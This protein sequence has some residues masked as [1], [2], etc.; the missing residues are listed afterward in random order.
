MQVTPADPNGKPRA[1][2]YLLAAAVV[3]L[4][5]FAA[6]TFGS[7]GREAP[8]LLFLPAV[9]FALAVGG[10]RVAIFSTILSGLAVDFFLLTP[11][12][13]F[14]L[15]RQGL[16]KEFFFV[17]TTIA[18]AWFFERHRSR[19]ENFLRLQRKLLEGA[20]E[21]MLIT[22]LD[23]H[24]VYWNQGA[25]QFYGWTAAEA[26]GKHPRELLESTSPE[27]SWQD[28]DSQLKQDG[29]WHGRLSR[30]CKDGRRVVTESS[31]AIDEKS[32]LILQTDLDVTRQ[33]NTESDLKRANRAL[34]ILSSVNQ[35]LNDL[36]SEA[37]LLQ[38]TV[39]VLVKNGGYPLAWVAIRVDDPEHSVRVGA[40]AGEASGYLSGIELS[41]AEDKPTGRG[42]C[43]TTLRE[44]QTTVYNDFLAAE[45]CSPWWERSRKFDLRSTMCVPLLVQGENQAALFVYASEVNAFHDQEFTLV[46]EVASD[47]AF[48]WT[49]LRLHEQAEEERKSR[50]TLEE[51][52]RQ[53]QKMEAIGR[54]AGGISHDFNNLLMVIM[55]QTELLAMQLEGPAL[56]RTE[57]VMKSARRAAE[58]T[59]QLLAFSRKQIVQPAILSLNPI[60]AEM[61]N[62]AAHVV[63]EDVE[64]TTSFSD[65]L[66]AVKVD[67]SQIEQVVMNLIVNARD[68]MPNGGKLLLETANIDLTTEYIATHPL[69]P[70][71]RY[72]RLVVSDTGVG[73]SDETKARLFEPFFTTKPP[74]KGTG[75]GLS[76]VYGIVKQSQGFVWYY[77][78]LGKGT[79]FK[80][81]LPAAEPMQSA[82]KTELK[83]E[84][85]PAKVHPM[86]L[87]VE[88][89]QSLREVITEFLEYAGYRVIAAES[90]E[91][92]IELAAGHVGEIDLL[93][94][95]ILLRGRNGKELADDLR[96]EGCKFK[97]IFMSG[98][99][100]N[101]IVHHGVLDDSI[102][103]LQKPF[104][105]ATLLAKVHE[106]L[107]L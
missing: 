33:S 81:Y 89:E 80:I 99:T 13:S 42:P 20:A 70:P 9:L 7:L 18:A 100:A 59:H 24:V 78:E 67:R 55:A 106:S 75:L 15:T 35:V 21:S 14:R 54:L 6:V 26:I 23:H 56:A 86:V 65:G 43:G 82:G 44:G 1:T 8:F 51:Q 69:V 39:E 77:S 87:L 88:D 10:F 3:A 104:T 76:M 74:G 29:R 22:D 17:A 4:A 27:M 96:G 46:F 38:R 5:T 31:W 64:I 32:G 105:R 36:S 98:Y 90:D 79:S 57:S 30:K 92:A 34:S 101:A 97:V 45:A 63:G 50:V 49:S 85:V 71:G 94:T 83:H 61:A 40:S 103:F 41:W 47:L 58:L 102:P 66:W 25:E 12:H 91:D 73:M 52:L 93:L 53:A 11:T 84:T 107:D 48:A 62:M 28:I 16:I 37:E 68:A 19:T 72:V 2:N 60:F 95:D